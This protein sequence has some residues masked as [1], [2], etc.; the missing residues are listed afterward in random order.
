MIL[1][2]LPSHRIRQISGSTLV[3][4][5]Q[6]AVAHAVIGLTGTE[7]E[8]PYIDDATTTEDLNVILHC[9]YINL[10]IFN[11]LFILTSFEFA[12]LLLCL[13]LCVQEAA[14]ADPRERSSSDGALLRD[15]HQASTAR[16][17]FP[18]S[19]RGRSN[20]RKDTSRRT[21]YMEAMESS[22]DLTVRFHYITA[23]CRTTLYQVEFE[24][25]YGLQ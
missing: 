16:R 23:V 15:N 22:E 3:S 10:T 20:K 11:C 19:R 8:F 12:V 4:P 24:L 17:A 18:L 6:Q 2:R 25:C 13:L 1:F 21:S 7:G 5:K 14:L 9:F